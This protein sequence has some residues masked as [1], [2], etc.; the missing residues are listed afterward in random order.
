MNNIQRVIVLLLISGIAWMVL[1][2]LR[3]G[4]LDDGRQ[5]VIAWLVITAAVGFFLF[6]TKK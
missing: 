1:N 3:Y 6:R 5:F 4:G 2:P